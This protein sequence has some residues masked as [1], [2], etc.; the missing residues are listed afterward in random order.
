M[1]ID[2][3]ILALARTYG[4]PKMN[5][6]EARVAV[7]LTQLGMSPSDWECQFHLGPFRL[8]FAKVPERVD[9]EVDG[10]VHDNLKIRRQDRRRDKQLSEWGWTVVRIAIDDTEDLKVWLAPLVRTLS[11]PARDKAREAADGAYA[12][13]IRSQVP[14]RC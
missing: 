11:P 4:W 1:N 12:G 8:D 10:W 7:A 14:W 3:L 5:T 6:A 9:P 2:Q 13:L